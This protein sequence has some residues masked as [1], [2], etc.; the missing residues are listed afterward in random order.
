MRHR[1]EVQRV[2]ET[3]GTQGG[4]ARTY[5]TVGYRY[6]SI[7]PVTGREYFDANRTQSDV[8][9]RIRI[10]PYTGLTPGGYRFRLGSRVFN[11]V[12]VLDLEERQ[13]LFEI[14]CTEEV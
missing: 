3:A 8:T 1:V 11:I 13:A 2:T 7:D 4:T 5:A 6:G 14:M 12:S 10:R 9:H